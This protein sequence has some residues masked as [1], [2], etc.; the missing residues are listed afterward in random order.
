[1]RIYL[2]APLFSQIQRAWNRRLGDAIAA[3]LHDATV[4]LPQDFR[5][6]GRFNDPRHYTVLFR[7]CLEELTRSDVLLAVLDGSDVDSGV[8]FEMGVAHALGKTVVGVRTDFRPGAAHGVNMMCGKACRY[9]VREFAFQEDPGV[10]AES[11][12][13]RLRAIRRKGA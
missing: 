2:A 7:K 9:M 6:E 1:M 5:T 11:V 4:T 10:V 3:A 12:I 13:R 8:A